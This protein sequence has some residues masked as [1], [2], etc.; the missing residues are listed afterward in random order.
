VIK[1][2]HRRVLC[3]ILL[4]LWLA[5]TPVVLGYRVHDRW[6][7]HTAAEPGALAYQCGQQEGWYSV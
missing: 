3:T 6:Y 4:G 2:T 5:V 7:M 1:L